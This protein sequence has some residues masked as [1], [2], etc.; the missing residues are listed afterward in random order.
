MVERKLECPERSIDK[1][2][3]HDFLLKL[4]WS[5]QGMVEETRE[6]DNQEKNMDLWEDN[7]EPRYYTGFYVDGSQI[8]KTKF[9]HSVVL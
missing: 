5:F 6:A 2:R 4:R 7:S 3:S 8:F 1:I 9:I